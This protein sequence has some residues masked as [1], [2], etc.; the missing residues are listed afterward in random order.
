MSREVE[1]GSRVKTIAE[2]SA[3]RIEDKS[4]VVLQVNCRIGY[5][6]V[7]ELWN[8][9]DT[10]TPDVVVGTETCLKE[11]ISNAEFFSADFTTFRRDMSAP[12]W[13]GVYLF[14]NFLASAEL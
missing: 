13:W 2:A 7:L 11:G 9:V 12:W 6:K 4:L 3:N 8:S 14:N 1:V 5:D 10:Y